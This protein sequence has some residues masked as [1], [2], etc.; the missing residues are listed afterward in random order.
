MNTW[1]RECHRVL[2]LF[3]R[4]G[5]AGNGG[6]GDGGSVATFYGGLLEFEYDDALRETLEIE[7]DQLDRLSQ[8]VFG[9]RCWIFSR[10]LWPGNVTEKPCLFMMG[11]EDIFGPTYG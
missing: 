9:P 8:R 1:C 10:I 4:S 6:A 11:S 3:H 5:G 2:L 7:D